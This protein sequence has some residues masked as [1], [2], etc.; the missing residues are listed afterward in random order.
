[1]KHLNDI[2]KVSIILDNQEPYLQ[3]EMDNLGTKCYEKNCKE[4]TSV[5][6]IYLYFCQY[7]HQL[8]S[9]TNL[10]TLSIIN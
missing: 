3:G 7:Q 6:K 2:F 4:V 5:T 1:M 9:L 10:Q 8:E